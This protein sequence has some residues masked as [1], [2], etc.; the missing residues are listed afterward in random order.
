M[1]VASMP[2]I[3]MM[4]VAVVYRNKNRETTAEYNQQHSDYYESNMFHGN[5]LLF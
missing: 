1:S 5:G 2:A 3:I 4:P